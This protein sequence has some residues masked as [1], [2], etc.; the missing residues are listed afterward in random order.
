MDEY[1][2]IKKTAACFSGGCILLEFVQVFLYGSGHFPGEVGIIF[3][4]A[5]GFEPFVKVRL[6]GFYRQKLLQLFFVHPAIA[7]FVDDP[8]P[9]GTGRLGPV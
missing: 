6:T 3:P 7:V 1:S 9:G 8:F 2:R 5:K 4:R